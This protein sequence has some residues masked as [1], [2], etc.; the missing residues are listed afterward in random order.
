TLNP[1]EQLVNK[2][3]MSLKNSSI[4][5]SIWTTKPFSPSISF[6]ESKAWIDNSTLY[7]VIKMMP[8]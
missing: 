6:F 4:Q 7:G 3:M 1:K 8:K 2:Y 5:E